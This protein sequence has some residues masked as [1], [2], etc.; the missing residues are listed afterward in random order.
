MI[1]AFEDPR[2]TDLRER[3][4]LA[5]EAAGLEVVEIELIAVPLES[6]LKG[7]ILGDV[8]AIDGDGVR[9]AFYVRTAWDRPVPQWIASY[10]HAA[11]SL[12]KVQVHVVV[13]QTSTALEKSCLACGAGL[14]QVVSDGDYRLLKLIDPSEYDPK[15]RRADL[16]ARAK[17]LRRRLETKLDANLKP[18]KDKLAKL[19]DLTKGMTA[20][21]QDE[22]EE[23]I[24]N[25]ISRLYEW[26]DQVSQL[27]D[28]G[29]ANSDENMLAT[30]DRRISE[31]GNV[32]AA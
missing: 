11:H 32:D 29:L 21:K 26:S 15:Q 27:L 31:E 25:S 19:P 16:E 14:L 20:Q 5:V 7:G 30:A 8:R 12:D 22:Y 6:G 28:G 17:A 10:A 24:E 13:E 1:R 3:V 4:S 18:L 23:R 2:K 9:H